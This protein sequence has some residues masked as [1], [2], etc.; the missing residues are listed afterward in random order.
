VQKLCLVSEA[1]L[2]IV[3]NLTKVFSLHQLLPTAKIRR[4]LRVPFVLAVLFYEKL[5]PNCHTL[6][7]NLLDV[8]HVLMSL[9]VNQCDIQVNNI[10]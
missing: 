7:E 4:R 3:S 9:G 5:C 10:W 2:S 6:H 1:W 8:D